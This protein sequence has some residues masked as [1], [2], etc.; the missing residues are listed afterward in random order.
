LNFSK[1]SLYFNFFSKISG[2]WTPMDYYPYWTTA[3]SPSP[4]LR[5][6]GGMPHIKDFSRRPELATLRFHYGDFN[7]NVFQHLALDDFDRLVAFN[8]RHF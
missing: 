6:G 8:L 1:L 2:P 7:R 4:G 3:P 5:G